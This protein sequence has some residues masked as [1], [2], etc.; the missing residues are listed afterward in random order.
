MPKK[1][2]TKTLHQD[3]FWTPQQDAGDDFQGNGNPCS[4]GTETVDQNEWPLIAGDFPRFGWAYLTDVPTWNSE[5][6]TKSTLN[7]GLKDRC[8]TISLPSGELT[9]TQLE[10]ILRTL[11]FELTFVDAADTNR[12]FS[13][14]TPAFFLGP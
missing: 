11:P 12:F 14:S 1:V 7:Q 13:E 2:M 3:T 10:G 6:L 4:Y 8:G 9:V 5:S